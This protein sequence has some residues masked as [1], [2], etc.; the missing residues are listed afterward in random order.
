MAKTE[1]CYLKLKP[2]QRDAD[3]SHYGHVLVVGGDK[4][5][6]GAVILAAEAALRV[7]AGLVSIITQ[8][9]HITACASRCP[10]AMVH[11]W[12]SQDQSVIEHLLQRVSVIVLGPGLGQSAWSHALWQ[13]FIQ[14]PQPKIIDADALNLLAQI[15]RQSS[16]WVLTPH[17]GEAA[18]LLACSV[19]DIQ[20]DRVQAVHAIQARYGGICVLKGAGTLVCDGISP[21]YLC[22]AGNPG[23]ASGGMGD[24]LSGVLGGLLA[25]YPNDLFKIVAFAVFVHA[26]AADRAAKQ[27]ERGMLACDVIKELR[28][29]V[30]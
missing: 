14:A 12:D 3:K 24:V 28:E 9:A 29:V 18:R 23:M 13:R 25:Q 1:E 15:P 21:D 26:T 8:P 11:G 27:G 22:H 19:K 10:E 20:A 4:G 30:N 2:R 16:N 6:P 7:G 17:P 5:M